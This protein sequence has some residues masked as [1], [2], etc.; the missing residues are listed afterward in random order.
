MERCDSQQC[1]VPNVVSIQVNKRGKWVPH[2]LTE[3]NK[4]ERVRLS[5]EL[6]ER[7]RRGDLNLDTIVTSDEKWVLY[8]NVVRRNSWV[9]S[10]TP[11]VAVARSGLH[12]KK[13]LLSVW[14]DSEGVIH[15]ELLPEGETITAN[16]YCEQLERVQAALRELRSHRT[17]TLLLHDNAT[18]HTARVT[19]CKLQ[20]LGW[21]VLPHPAYSPDL[22]PTDFKLFRSLANTLKDKSFTTSEEVQAFIG[23]FFQSKSSG[24][25]VRG[26]T[27]LP[28]RWEE[29]IEHEG[30][31]PPE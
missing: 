21:E 13:V 26:F 11:A 30:E 7:Y 22:A 15:W 24:F 31:Y 17:A 8:T 14:W 29:V 4:A 27:A 19:K 1:E 6:L 16:L 10:G 20:E 28:E 3:R 23:D 25:F 5:T 2:L 12:P 18:P 9:D